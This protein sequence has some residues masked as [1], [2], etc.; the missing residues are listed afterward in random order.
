MQGHATFLS[1]LIERLTGL[2]N[3][4][5]LAGTTA[6]M[7]RISRNSYRETN[8]ELTNVLNAR[9]GLEQYLSCNTASA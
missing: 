8:G 6:G 7:P 2:Q 9:I 5:F 1:E 3:D 4:L